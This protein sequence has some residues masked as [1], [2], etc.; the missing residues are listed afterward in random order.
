METRG[1]RVTVYSVRCK[2]NCWGSKYSWA[3]RWGDP[4]GVGDDY[5]QMAWRL[6]CLLTGTLSIWWPRCAVGRP[7]FSALSP[8]T[9][10]TL[11]IILPAALQTIWQ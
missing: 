6:V 1:S 2:R 8:I 11:H 9:R 7:S 5:A 3:P 10:S 4:G